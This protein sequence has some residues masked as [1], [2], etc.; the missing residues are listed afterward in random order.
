MKLSLIRNILLIFILVALAL[1][2]TVMHVY[3]QV[4]DV[5]IYGA[6]SNSVVRISVY[7]TTNAVSSNANSVRSLRSIS[8]MSAPLPPIVIPP[9]HPS[10]LP[11]TPM[12]NGS[13]RAYDAVAMSNYF[14]K[15]LNRK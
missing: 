12:A 15:P 7:L 11:L 8:T 2:L 13:M 14:S 9:T 10:V 3:G 1:I 4:V 6:S 5:T